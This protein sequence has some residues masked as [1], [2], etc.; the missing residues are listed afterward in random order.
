MAKDKSKKKDADTKGKSKAAANDDFAKPSEAP[1]GGDGWNLTEEAEDR[2]ILFTPLREESVETQNF[3][4]KPV[5]VCD[6]VVIDEKKPAKSEVHEEVFVFG[7]FLRGSLKGF[8]GERK[9]LGRLYK[10]EVQKK[11]QNAPWMLADATEE[12]IGKAREYLASLDPFKS[13]K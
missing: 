7:G 2:L 6:V 1:A 5:I 3:G 12:E 9:V 8:I 4:A 13:K 10:G 11:G